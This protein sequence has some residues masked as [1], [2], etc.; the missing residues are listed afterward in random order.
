MIGFSEQDGAHNRVLLS[1]VLTT[2]DGGAAKGYAGIPQVE[3]A[4]AVYLCPQMPPLGGMVHVS[5]PKP[6]SWRMRPRTKLKVLWVRQPLPCMPWL[7]CRYTKPKRFKQMHEGSSDWA[8]QRHS[9]GLCPAVLGGAEA[10]RGDPAHPAPARCTV[11][12]RCP[13]DQA[14]CVLQSCSALR[15]IDT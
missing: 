7:S 15:W 10:D 9:R 4:V 12:H 3:R 1:S 14:S 5:H 11:T 2:L 13:W 8:V 6:V